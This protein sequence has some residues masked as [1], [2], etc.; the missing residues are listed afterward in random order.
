MQFLIIATHQSSQK[1]NKYMTLRSN[2]FFHCKIQSIEI[3]IE[4]T[5]WLFS[6]ENEHENRENLKLQVSWVLHS[7]MIPMHSGG[8]TF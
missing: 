2:E 5:Q 7:M 6:K 4:I 8:P 1:L 3:L